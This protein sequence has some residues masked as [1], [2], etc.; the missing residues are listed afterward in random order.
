MR[1]QCGNCYSYWTVCTFLGLTFF[2]GSAK[3]LETLTPLPTPNHSIRQSSQHVR[4]TLCASKRG[5]ICSRTAATFSSS[6]LVTSI[7]PEIPSSHAVTGVQGAGIDVLFFWMQKTLTQLH[8]TEEIHDL[9]RSSSVR[10]RIVFRESKGLM[11]LAETPTKAS[12]RNSG[13]TNKWAKTMSCRETD[14]SSSEE[15]WGSSIYI[16]KEKSTQKGWSPP[17][18]RRPSLVL[19]EIHD[20]KS[21]Y[22]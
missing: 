17:P 13:N 18:R 11:K 2:L 1:H 15:V 20:T 9:G 14:Q 7:L 5:F 12:C 19:V 3:R 22:P 16:H 21:P 4:S 8:L 10:I 6:M